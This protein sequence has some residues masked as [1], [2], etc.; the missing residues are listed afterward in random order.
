M[1]KVVEIIRLE[2]GKE[3]TLG[4]LRINK[5]V[6]CVTLEPRDF[7][8]KQNISC[9]PAQPY[10]CRPVESPRFG[11]TFEVTD[12]PGR[13]HI[14]FHAGNLA[15]HTE[16]CILLGETIGKLKGQRAVLNSGN[17]FRNFL[18][19]MGRKPFRLVILE[20]Y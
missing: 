10:L 7:G 11:G 3:G 14:L 17:T 5:E 9:I 8:N 18:A 12:V 2:T 16:G 1:T 13:S 6:F 20:A 15:E 4:V 19:E